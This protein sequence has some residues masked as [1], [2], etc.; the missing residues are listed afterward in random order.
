MNPN[1]WTTLVAEYLVIGTQGA[2]I[3]SLLALRLVGQSPAQIAKW[4]G[5]STGLSSVAMTVLGLVVAYSL[6]ILLDRTWGVVV[7]AAFKPRVRRIWKSVQ[8]PA[9]ERGIG[10]QFYLADEGLIGREG[11]RE[12]AFRRR[13]RL[14]IVR[15]LLFHVPLLAIAVLVHHFAWW[16]VAAAVL[17]EG[18]TIVSFLQVHKQYIT[19]VAFYHLRSNAT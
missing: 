11:V 7:R 5:A 13:G 14:R 19:K 15:A 6:G 1:S 12:Q 9:G 2:A 18:M 17:F 3:V 10:Q 16:I 8:A 4:V